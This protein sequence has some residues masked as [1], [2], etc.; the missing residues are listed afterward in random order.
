MDQMREYTN[1]SSVRRAVDEEPTGAWPPT[2]PCS[3]TL[4]RSEGSQTSSRAAAQRAAGGHQL[5]PFSTVA[6]AHSAT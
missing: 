3:S 6:T 5:T 4:C 1:H 2:A